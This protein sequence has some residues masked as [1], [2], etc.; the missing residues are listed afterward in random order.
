[1]PGLEELA[2]DYQRRGDGTVRVYGKTH[3]VTHPIA[4]FGLESFD[5]TENETGG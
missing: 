1:V 5:V 4:S 3:R 2:A